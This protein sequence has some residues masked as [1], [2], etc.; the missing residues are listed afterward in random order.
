M[1]FKNIVTYNYF[2]KIWFNINNK[3]F[4]KKNSKKTLKNEHSKLQYIHFVTKYVKKILCINLKVFF[5]FLLSHMINSY[6]SN[7]LCNL[8][9]LLKN[10]ILK[11]NLSAN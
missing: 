5:T 9:I 8:F 3:F 2:F 7:I 6:D 10:F 1:F 11:K 4:K